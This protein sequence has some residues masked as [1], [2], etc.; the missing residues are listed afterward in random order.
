M[1]FRKPFLAALIALMAPVASHAAEDY[2]TRQELG[3]LVRDYIIEHPEVIVES[4]TAYQQKAQTEGLEQTS[5]AIKENRPLIFDDA[6]TPYIGDKDAPLTIVEFFDYNCSACKYM[7]APIDAIHKE[8]TKDVKI[9]FKEFPI[10][11]EVSERLA[12]IGL[13]IHALA[14]EKYYGFH[15]AMM[16]HKGT[17]SAQDA[18]GYAKSVGV[19]RE[20]IEKELSKPDYNERIKTNKALGDVLAIRGTPFL[21]IGDEPVPHAIDES[22]LRTR[23]DAARKALKQ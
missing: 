20:V 21:I 13:A 22:E 7:F 10:F 16:T 4:M 14:P 12:K 3:A 8:G 15:T 11:G 5:K 1:L 2:V 6:H 23:L 17:I 18:Y 19:T 9:L